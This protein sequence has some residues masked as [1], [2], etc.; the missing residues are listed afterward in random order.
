MSKT[1]HTIST[2]IVRDQNSDINYI[3]T[4]NSLI[5]ANQIVEKFQYG[6]S[7]FSII[8]SY[9]TG[10]SSFLWALQ[11]NLLESKEY[12]FKLNGQFNGKS[13]FEAVNI[14]GSYNSLAEIIQK[15]LNLKDCDTENLLLGLATYY[16]KIDKEG[17]VL[18]IFIDEFGKI[19]EYS[20]T[21]QPE[22]SMYFIQQFAEFCNDPSRDIIF[23]TTLHQN[24]GAYT[25]KLTFS[26]KQEWVKT[27][28]R[29]EDL[30]FN[31]PVEQLLLL[32]AK[33]IQ[34]WNVIDITIGDQSSDFTKIAEKHYHLPNGLKGNYELSQQL[35]PLEI[36]AATMLTKALQRYGQN[37]RSLFT[38]LN[39]T[40]E[41]GIQEYFKNN[42]VFSIMDVFDYI[43]S[44][45]FSFL[46]TTLNE[47]KNYW[48]ALRDTLLRTRNIFGSEYRIGEA[49][50][51]IIGLTNLL[52]EPG[53]HINEKFIT[54]YTKVLNY[55]LEEVQKALN[56]LVENKIIYYRKYA[57]RYVLTEG[58]DINYELE[59][60]KASASIDLTSEIIQDVKKYFKKTHEIARRVSFE[61]GTSRFFEYMLTEK[62]ITLTPDG[63]IDG[64]INIVFNEKIK[65]RDIKGFS[66]NID[67]AIV[68]VHFSDTL[69]A[70][71][72]ISEIKKINHVIKEYSHDRTAVKELSLRKNTAIKAL[73]YLLNESI[74]GEDSQISW[75]FQGE[76]L[77]VKNKQ[78]LNRHLSVIV[79]KVYSDTP[80]LR[81]ELFNKHSY[82]SQISNARKNYIKNLLEFE[83]QELIGFSEENF[84]PEKTIYLTLLKDTG[85]HQQTNDGYVLS[86]PTQESFEYLWHISQEYLQ[87]T[88]T[89]KLSIQNLIDRLSK[90][91]LKLKKGFVD[92]WIPTF[93][94]IHKHEYALFN[95]NI[96][97][98]FLSPD[99]F[100]LIWKNP[101]NFFIKCYNVD[102][103][104]LNIFN[105]YRELISKTAQ[106]EVNQILFLETIKP[107]LLFYRE[108]PE[109]SKNTQ[110]LSEAAISLRNAISSSPDPETAFFQE[111]P[112]ALGYKAA[113]L[114]NK[115]FN[116][117]EYVNKLQNAIREIRSSYDELLNR[118]EIHF[119][120]ATGSKN[121]SYL[122]LKENLSKRFQ[123]INIEGL[124]ALPKKLLA[125]IRA[126][127]DSKADFFNSI[128]FAL[129]GK[130]M[131]EYADT[132]EPILYNTF[133]KQFSLLERVLPIHQINQ[134]R[135]DESVYGLDITKPNGE[136]VEMNLILEKSTSKQQ[137]LLE[138]ELND[139]TKSL[140][141]EEKVKLIFTHL[142]RI[143]NNES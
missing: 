75:F 109:Y 3:V 37:E 82:S 118:F 116:L 33:K 92:F 31:E 39:N 17:K 40:S 114:K 107:F 36:I 32:A 56:S 93:L 49:L 110:N 47:D 79:E 67:E 44:N 35:F 59:L 72:Y 121:D 19:L 34:Q 90:K 128:S 76:I 91:P 10:K 112:Q 8:G 55:P 38:F 140:P 60:T 102:G 64:I 1:K 106:T 69:K 85:I 120:K 131:K 7:S 108:L 61:K 15:E 22:K 119:R 88:K 42:K 83:S 135:K 63:E 30:T 70:K 137:V 24:F 125:R 132:D 48:D 87:D 81:N 78:Q 5:I 138:K 111:F 98:P 54:D 62:P 142:N 123:D 46:I 50:I 96:Y 80:I 41:N 129:T 84:P 28:G 115:D 18:L 45:Y 86:N 124:A 58:T 68:Y 133:S 29:F 105:K 89:T 141:K 122:E 103:V 53:S 11:K 2:N 77:P 100:D 143:L 97:V 136:K 117:E 26:Q 94:I 21:H 14:V 139:L 20:A 127:Y 99:L 74:F 25:E 12:F 43:Y 4:P 66:E 113:D 51:K 6:Q 27:K 134:S 101:E 16:K 65:A 95:Q 130:S 104:K 13:K 57:N 71:D 23:I 9:G 126:P 52:S 73:N